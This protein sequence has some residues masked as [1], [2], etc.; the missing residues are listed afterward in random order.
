MCELALVRSK[1]GVWIPR[2][3]WVPLGKSTKPP[4]L[5]TTQSNI[6]PSEGPPDQRGS[7]QPSQPSKHPLIPMKR[8]PANDQNKEL[9][10][11]SKN[12]IMDKPLVI[13]SSFSTHSALLGHVTRGNSPKA[14]IQLLSQMPIRIDVEHQKPV[15]E[16]YGSNATI[17][18]SRDSQISRPKTGPIA[19]IPICCRLGFIAGRG[20]SVPPIGR[21][22]LV[23]FS[24]AMGIDMSSGHPAAI[25]GTKLPKP[26]A[27]HAPIP[28]VL[29]FMLAKQAGNK[30]NPEGLRAY[31]SL[32][33]LITLSSLRF[34][35]TADVSA[36]WLTDTAARGVSLNRQGEYGRGGAWGGIQSW[37]PRRRGVGGAHSCARGP[38][39]N[40]RKREI[41]AVISTRYAKLGTRL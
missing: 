29:L 33:L 41:R 6:D 11:I 35:D 32:F 26:P 18:I 40:I 7:V 14:T 22:S 12:D 30:E 3:G 27:K 36:S 5:L 38:I 34:S 28:L 2:G 20:L 8:R 10:A 16:F 37:F 21:Y 15:R 39:W 4:P 24:V 31:C 1:M 19:V 25:K 9:P 23:V 17:M 13:E